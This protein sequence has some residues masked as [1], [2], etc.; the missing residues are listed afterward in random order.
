ML[1][2]MAGVYYQLSLNG[3]G[4]AEIIEFFTS[5]S[6]HTQVPIVSSNPS[7]KMWINA[8]TEGSI[9]DGANAPGSRSQAVKSLVI[10]IVNWYDVPP[11]ELL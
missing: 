4:T 5:L 10:A 2:V 3:V 8:T 11:P 1:K 7:G 6:K 9:A